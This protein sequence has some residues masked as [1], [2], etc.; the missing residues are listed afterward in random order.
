MWK[1]TLDAT[2][3]PSIA[4]DRICGLCIKSP[5]NEFI[6]T[7]IGVYLPCA[8]LGTETYCEYLIELERIISDHQHL[9][10][11]VIMGDFIA[12][13]GAIGGERGVGDPNQ[14]GL[15]LHQLL[16][17]CN[18]YVVSL[19]LLATGPQYTFQNSVTQTTV[20]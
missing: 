19:S 4:S 8:D 15:L 11:V 12:H 14:Q 2:P 7:V 18:L 5:D 13:L 1:K 6:T 20:D 9:G 10:P 17:R 16:T 3:I